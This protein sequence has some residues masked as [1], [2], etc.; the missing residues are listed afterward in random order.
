[1]AG[2]E[3]ELIELQHRLGMERIEREHELAMQRIVEA[4][5]LAGERQKP[6][7][8]PGVTRQRTADSP[9]AT[10]LR[11]LEFVV[12]DTHVDPSPERL[13]AIHL[14]PDD[15]SNGYCGA[16]G[17][18]LHDFSEVTLAG[19]TGPDEGPVVDN[20]LGIVCVDCGLVCGAHD[21]DNDEG[22]FR[23]LIRP[24]VQLFE[25][26][27]IF[28][29]A[30]AGEREKIAMREGLRRMRIA[31]ANGLT[32][33]EGWLAVLDD[34]ASD[35]PVGNVVDIF[36]ERKP[37]PAALAAVPGPDDPVPPAD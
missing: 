24:G 26:I 5:R 19:G 4:D 29:G 37:K 14:C 30:P 15:T 27:K 8:A 22:V 17:T 23:T 10:R 7:D 25:A 13:G 16:C 21:G 32:R 28:D 35:A 33:I 9:L 31:F 36:S 12:E 1:M 11:D 20:C 3:R 2:D 18:A 34:P 6:V